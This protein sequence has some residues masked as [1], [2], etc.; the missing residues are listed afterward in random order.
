M[1]NASDPAERLRRADPVAEDDPASA[2]SPQAGALFE[3]ITVAPPTSSLVTNPPRRRL[4]TWVAIPVVVLLLAAAGYGLYHSIRQPLVV[5]CFQGGRLDANRFEVDATGANPVDLCSAPWR[6][7]G[8]FNPT[9]SQST[10]DL[11]ACVLSDG[12]IGVFPTTVS[13]D[14]CHT[15]G[16]EA[17]PVDSDTDVRQLARFRD[18]VVTAML[19]S[20]YSRDQA[21]DLVRTKLSE[22]GLEGWE[23]R[24][25]GRFTANRPC[26]SPDIEPAT[27]IVR[28][29]PIR[30]ASP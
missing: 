5:A 20:C 11:A 7:G 18:S 21:V 15:L 12:G 3:R 1:T 6:P 9:G 23:V 24:L 28:I 29:V 25:G 22:A 2:R 13:S 26:A 14:I 27:S 4:R 16:L 17:A 10:P 30:R 8:D 19:G